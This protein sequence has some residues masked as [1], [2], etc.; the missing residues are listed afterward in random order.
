MTTV[1]NVLD[2]V[3]TALDKAEVLLTE[4]EPARAIGYG[5]ALIVFA[6]AKV[7]GAIPDQS[8]DE[9]LAL[10]AAAVLSTTAIV[11]SIRRF[12]YSPATVFDL[13]AEFEKA[14]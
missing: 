11:E 12:V 4:K 14:D 5:A 7:S 9:S 13:L 10:G 2:A 3:K 8:L 6:I 1:S